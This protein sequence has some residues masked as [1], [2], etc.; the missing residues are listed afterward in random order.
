MN[1]IPSNLTL[2]GTVPL[3]TCVCSGGLGDFMGLCQWGRCLHQRSMYIWRF[4]N[5][6]SHLPVYTCDILAGKLAFFIW[7]KASFLLV[8][9][10][11]S[12]NSSVCSVLSSLQLCPAL[13]N[14]MDCSP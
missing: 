8:F 3:D 10:S 2:F 9:F 4:L 12:K 7:S 13:C 11:D 5:A 6:I 1:F 14:L